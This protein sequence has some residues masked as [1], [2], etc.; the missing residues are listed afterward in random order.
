MTTDRHWLRLLSWASKTMKPRGDDITLRFFSVYSVSKLVSKTPP[1]RMS[2]MSGVFEC[3]SKR[4]DSTAG[5]RNESGSELRTVGP[6]TE[7][8]R[9]PNVQRRNRG[10]FSLRWLAERRC[11]RPE[12]PETGTQQWRQWRRFW[13]GC[14]PAAWHNEIIEVYYCLYV[15]NV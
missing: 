4:S 12:T 13:Q 8:A 1:M 15:R 11:W 14:I 9:V 10:I 6:A 2:P 7:K 3:C 5:S